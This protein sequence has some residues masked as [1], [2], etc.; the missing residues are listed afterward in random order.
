[1]MVRSLCSVSVTP[2]RHMLIYLPRVFF[3]RLCSQRTLQFERRHVF[4]TLFLS[5]N[6]LCPDSC[7]PLCPFGLCQVPLR[8]WEAAVQLCK[9]GMGLWKAVHFGRALWAC[10]WHSAS[11]DV[12][13]ALQ[14]HTGV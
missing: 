10:G 9:V 4:L 3:C 8:L 1:M 6:I 7:V 14:M 5:V 2:H 11:A 13:S 12:L